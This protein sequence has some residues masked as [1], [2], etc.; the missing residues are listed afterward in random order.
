M[1]ERTHLDVKMF[2][3][4][5]IPENLEPVVHAEIF[6]RIIMD[7]VERIAEIEVVSIFES[8]R[9][10]PVVVRHHVLSVK[11][12]VTH[13]EIP[14][15]EFKVELRT[16]RTCVLSYVLPV[17]LKALKPSQSYCKVLEISL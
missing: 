11:H 5:R 3:G 4:E 1:E 12:S 10:C 16:V 2:V 17:V 7:T 15:P 6:R 9:I 14:L 13:A 8:S